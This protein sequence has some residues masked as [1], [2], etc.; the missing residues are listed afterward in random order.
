[1][2]QCGICED[3]SF[4]QSIICK[5]HMTELHSGFGW[6]CELCRVAMSR[7][8]AHR[9]FDGTLKLVNRSTMTCTSEEKEAYDIFKGKGIERLN[10][11][12]WHTSRILIAKKIIGGNHIKRKIDIRGLLLR[13]SWPSLLY[14]SPC[15]WGMGRLTIGQAMSLTGN[16]WIQQQREKGEGEHY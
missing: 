6:R 15:H 13:G 2:Y 12:R 10:W 8:Q 1:M 14:T 4:D 3:I 9:N 7:T 11:S 5:R 16:I